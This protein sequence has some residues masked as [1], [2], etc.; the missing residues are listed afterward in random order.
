MINKIIF[1]I[2]KLTIHLEIINLMKVV[3]NQLNYNNNNTHHKLIFNMH[4]IKIK[5]KIRLIMKTLKIINKY[6]SIH[7]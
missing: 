5:Y 4:K 1:S 6:Q 7:L 2:Y 3:N